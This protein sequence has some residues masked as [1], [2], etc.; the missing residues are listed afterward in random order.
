MSTT[1]LDLINAS[2]L[3]A[4]LKVVVRDVEGELTPQGTILSTNDKGGTY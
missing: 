3:T 4:G 2:L 1:L